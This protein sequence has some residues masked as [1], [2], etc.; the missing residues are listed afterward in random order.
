MNNKHKVLRDVGYY[1]NNRSKFNEWLDTLNQ[2]EL[3][4]LEL[5]YMREDKPKRLDYKEFCGYLFNLWEAK[6]GK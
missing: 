2:F 6:N 1:D 4:H 3:T 5:L